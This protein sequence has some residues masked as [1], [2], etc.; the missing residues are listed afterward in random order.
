MP[1]RVVT[2]ERADHRERGQVDR[3]WPQAG[4]RGCLEQTIDHVATSGDEDDARPRA[5]RG[6]DGPED[7]VLEHRLLERHR[8]VLL[9]LELDGG[10]NLLGIGERREVDRP[11]HDALVGDTQPHPLAELVLREQSPQN[12]R[13][14]VHVGDLAVANDARGKRRIGCVVDGDAAVRD[15]HSGDITRLDVEPYD[16]LVCGTHNEFRRGIGC[17]A[18]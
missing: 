7:L 12:L 4:A 5:V 2:V 15:L 13:E 17:S 8:D 10:G 18:L 6:L 1:A 9:S 3:G 11:H 16:C 14:G